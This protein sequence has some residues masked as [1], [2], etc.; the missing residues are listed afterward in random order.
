MKSGKEIRQELAD[1]FSYRP[2]WLKGLYRLRRPLAWILGIEHSLE[3]VRQYRQQ[4]I[5]FTPGQRMWIFEV[6][7]AAR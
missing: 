1:F 5:P 7:A 2:L 6:A 3:P 4:D